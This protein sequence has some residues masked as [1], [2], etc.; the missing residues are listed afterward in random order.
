MNSFTRN[1]NVEAIERAIKKGSIVL[2]LDIQRK[3]DQWSKSKK[4]L[5]IMSAI[6]GYIIPGV[7]AKEDGKIWYILDGKQRLSVLSQYLNNEFKLDKSLL[8][9]E[10]GER[11]A[12]K[13]FRDLD[14]DAKEAILSAEITFNIY[15][16]ITDEETEE[17]FFRL[18][19]GQPLSAS[20]V[21]RVI[22]GPQIRAF[23]DKAKEH[24]FL[25]VK[26]NIT[27]GKVKKSMDETVI[28]QTLML[29]SGY[30]VTDFTK[31]NI[32]KFVSEFRDTYNEDI[33]NKVLASMDYLDEIV[34]ETNK[35]LKII[36]LPMIINAASLVL[37]D[38][39][40]KKKFKTN[41][42]NFLNEYETREDYLQYCDKNTA[43]AANVKGRIEYFRAMTK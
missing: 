16:D 43:A 41:F 30:E 24:P 27:K 22:E 1:K 32:T 4:S 38:D 15:Q 5:L 21:Y 11:F 3:E 23:I 34:E 7:F 10:D 14:D 28:L 2:D 36:S 33:C 19:N 29:V 12:G 40:A 9:Y 31:A 25:T 35:S 17:I 20:N 6:Q 8:K 26:S 39:K 18:N 37:E 13:K 42:V